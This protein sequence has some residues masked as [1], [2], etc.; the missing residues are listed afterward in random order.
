MDLYVAVPA[1]LALVWI[2]YKVLSRNAV[3]TKAPPCLPSLPVIGSLPFLSGM[4]TLH[5]CFVEKAKRYGSVFAF[6]AGNQYAP[7]HFA[8]KHYFTGKL[9]FT[10]R[11]NSAATLYFKSKTVLYSKTLFCSRIFIVNQ[12]NYYDQL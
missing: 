9:D 4:D 10:A 2:V 3:H 1:T 8:T 12:P 7:F 5:L 11:L 6:Y